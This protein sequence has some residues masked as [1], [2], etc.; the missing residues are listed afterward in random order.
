MPDA[1][2]ARSLV[3]ELEKAHKRSHHGH[4]GNARHSPR[5]GFTGSFVLF[6]GTGLSCP[7]HRR[8]VSGPLGPTSPSRRLDTSVGASEPHDFSVRFAARPSCAP[9]SVHRIP[10]PTFVTTAKRP[11]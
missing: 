5:D 3:C 6:P 9:K 7:R 10:H 11:S 4:T 2:C 8:G 1:P